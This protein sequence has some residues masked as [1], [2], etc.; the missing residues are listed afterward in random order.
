MPNTIKNSPP[1]LELNPKIDRY[2]AE[3]C[4]RCPL[5]GTPECKV[6]S[7]TEELRALRQLVLDCELK[8]ELKWSMP[9]YTLEGANVAMV[10]AFKEYACLSFFKGSLLNDPEGLLVKPGEN[11]QAT[12]QLRFTSLDEIRARKAAILELIR[13]AIQ[14]ETS[15]KKVAFKKNPE[16][17]P[18]ELQT[19][20]GADPALK[21][22]FEALSPGRQRGYILHVSGAKQA[23]T[24][25][26]RV[27][28]HIPRIL[29]GKG[30][31]D[32]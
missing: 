28:K 25:M 2:L 32:R 16:P 21:A 3:G 17:I 19:R 10:S 7:W 1:P 31:H 4:G 22:A 14:L 24:R 26:A 23:A 11:S 13:Q 8:E 9:C 5:V 18:E 12:R 6:H 20:L 27:E 15:G 30:I 29:Q